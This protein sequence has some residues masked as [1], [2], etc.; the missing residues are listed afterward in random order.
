MNNISE[1]YTPIEEAGDLIRK[2][3]A[4]TE[5]RKKVEKEYRRVFF[6]FENRPFGVIGRHI[7]TPDR[8]FER[9]LKL[10]NKA[11]VDPYC[12]EQ[13]EDKFTAK[14][15]TKYAL[16]S[17][18]FSL[19]LNRNL[20]NIVKN[21]KIIDFN[22]AEG[23][24][25]SELKTLWGEGLVSFHHFFLQEIFPVMKGRLVDTS[26]WF[27]GSS[28][29]VKCYY[30]LVFTL[31]VSNSILFEDFDLLKEENN[32]VAKTVIPIFNE[33]RDRFGVKP[34]IVKISNVGEHES[35]PYWYSYSEKLKE[36]MDTHIK[37]FK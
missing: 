10:C 22:G 29:R 25:L 21:E 37:K 20:K 17:L 6:P 31:A 8:E 30:E 1:I 14:N 32:F 36:V 3:W 35:D 5:L 18:P 15:F 16:T 34:I 7:G 19:G 27:L 33:I 12:F 24:K 2:R 23:K 13:T 11:G 28:D 9:F 26:N 4:D